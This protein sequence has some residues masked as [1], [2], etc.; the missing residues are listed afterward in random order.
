MTFD[1]EESD[2]QLLLLSLGL[3]ALLR[4]GFNYACG[5]I[6]EKLDGS[7]GRFEE[8]KRLNDDQVGP[9]GEPPNKEHS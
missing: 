6:A 9:Q 2:R 8:F 3:C 1:I 4:P 7:R 5:N